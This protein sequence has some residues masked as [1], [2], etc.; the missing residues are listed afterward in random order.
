MEVGC[1]NAT[2]FSASR[3]IRSPEQG[4]VPVY[5]LRR[6]VR[7]TRDDRAHCHFPAVLGPSDDLFEQKPT[8][9]ESP[10]WPKQRR[11]TGHESPTLTS[12]R[13]PG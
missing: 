13:K 8:S 1:K 11:P 6:F 4:S 3:M 2:S 12:P 5:A 10:L 9:A 7:I